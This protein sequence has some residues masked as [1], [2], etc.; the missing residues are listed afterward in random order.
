MTMVDDADQK[1]VTD[2]NASESSKRVLIISRRGPPESP[3]GWEIYDSSGEV[4]RSSETFSARDE[5]VSD[6][7][8]ALDSSSNL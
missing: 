2:P 4:A 1:S 8:R 6:G 7:Q 5:A 3:F